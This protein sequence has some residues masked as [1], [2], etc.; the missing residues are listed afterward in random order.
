MSPIFVDTSA[1]LALLDRSDARHEIARE[2]F[3]DLAAAELVTSGYVVAESLAVTRRRFG[4]DGAIALID[5][6][7]PTIDVLPV[8]PAE[9]ETILAAYRASLPAG[10][11]FVDRVSLH[12][13]ERDSIAKAF[14]FDQDLASGGAVVLPR[15]T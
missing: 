13:M 2:T 10:I 15:H 12:V 6:L 14:A 1:I 3:V 8:T 11:S 9:H 4:V 7:L 5:G